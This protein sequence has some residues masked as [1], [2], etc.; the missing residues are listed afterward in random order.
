MQAW[1]PE[2][3]LFPELAAGRAAAA[4]LPEP[5]WPL[6]PEP[7]LDAPLLPLLPPLEVLELPLL[8]EPPLE[9][10]EVLEVPL[11]PELPLPPELE[12]D[13]QALPTT[14]TSAWFPEVAVFPMCTGP[15]GN[16]SMTCD[17]WLLHLLCWLG[18]T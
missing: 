8:P 1:L 4:D 12:L 13:T 16:L 7:P 18:W 14:T 17:A 15:C 5:P 10:L 9:V 11:L 3:P 2:L 6:L